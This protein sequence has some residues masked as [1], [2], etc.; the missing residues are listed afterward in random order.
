MLATLL[1]F[2]IAALTG[3]GW[4]GVEYVLFVVGIL[5]FGYG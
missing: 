3:T 1:S 4:V 2:A 5:G